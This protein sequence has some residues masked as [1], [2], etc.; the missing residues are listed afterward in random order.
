[1][2]GWHVTPLA[3]ALKP[4]WPPPR[5][6]YDYGAGPDRWGRYGPVEVGEDG[7]SRSTWIPDDGQAD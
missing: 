3:D 7:I 4:D 2:D 6:D 5:R 1:M